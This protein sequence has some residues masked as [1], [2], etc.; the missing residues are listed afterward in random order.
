[1][2]KNYLSHPSEAPAGTQAT[3][4]QVIECNEI[5]IA[6]CLGRNVATATSQG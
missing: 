5:A 4:P 2:K 3:A 1:M 6:L